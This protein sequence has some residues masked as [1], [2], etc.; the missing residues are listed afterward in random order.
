MSDYYCAIT[1][2]WKYSDCVGLYVQGEQGEPCMHGPGGLGCLVHQ[3]SFTPKM[4]NGIN[5][6][7]MLKT[8]EYNLSRGNS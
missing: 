7:N 2:L 4:M 8:D 3:H 5:S 1:K 6:K